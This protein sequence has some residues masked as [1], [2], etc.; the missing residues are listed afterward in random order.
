MA[1]Y[2]C[3]NC[4]CIEN[5]ALGQWHMRNDG[6]LPESHEGKALC[7][8]CAATEYADGS[9]AFSGKWHGKFQKQHVM[10]FLK[11]NSA[12]QLRNWPMAI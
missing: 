8:E 4:H 12:D 10:E 9:P 6:I 3:E 1:L 11:E 5:T 2:V 7:S